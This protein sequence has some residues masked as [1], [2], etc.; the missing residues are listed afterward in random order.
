VTVEPE[1]PVAPPSAP[2]P[3]EP[4]TPPVEAATTYPAGVE[5]LEAAERQE[6]EGRC[7]P[8]ADAVAAR[9]RK[10]KGEKRAIQFVDEVLAAPPAIAGVDVPRCAALMAR[11]V[12][13][14]EAKSAES[15]AVMAL[16]RV[17]IGVA[18]AHQQAPA[19]L[20]ASAPKVPVDLEALARGPYSSTASDWASPGWQC[21]RFDLAGQPQRFQYELR[22]DP[23]ARTFVVIARGFPAGG[24]RARPEE[25]FLEGRVEGGVIEPSSRVM[26]GR[27]R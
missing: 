15:E 27:A 19:A 20:C 4:S 7:K 18:T 26:R 22:V 23:A 24:D 10:S 1:R 3:V 5:P 8:L 6:L 17:M 2:P 21:A 13:A 16:K 9:A 11:D 25:L 14:Y 12:R